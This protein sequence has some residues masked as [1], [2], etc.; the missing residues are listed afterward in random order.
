M[1]EYQL[2]K[3]PRR[4]GSG[5]QGYETFHGKAPRRKGGVDLH[6]PKELVLLGEAVAVE[7][8]CNKLNGGGDG[9]K[10][11]YRH[12]FDKGAILAM[13]ETKRV[14]LYIIGNKIKVTDAGIEH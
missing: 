4:N 1:I 7:Y 2:T 14:Q 12:K 6:V 3:T 8:R 11:V 9:T 10:A 5:E 13:D